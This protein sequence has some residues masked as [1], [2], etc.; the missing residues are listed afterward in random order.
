MR[1]GGAPSPA[2]FFLGTWFF[3]YISL[4]F[5]LIKTITARF[6][7][8]PRGFLSAAETAIWDSSWRILDF[9]GVSQTKTKLKINYSF[10]K[11]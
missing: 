7:I 8:S 10:S 2:F 11:C 4:F 3:K 9:K 5:L 6:E 1:W